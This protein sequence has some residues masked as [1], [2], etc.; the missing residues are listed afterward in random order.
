MCQGDETDVF[1]IRHHL[2]HKC[3]IATFYSCSRDLN[4]KAFEINTRRKLYLRFPKKQRLQMDLN[5]LWNYI[6]LHIQP[7]H[8]TQLHTAYLK[9]RYSTNVKS[10]LNLEKEKKKFFFYLNTSLSKKGYIF[11]KHYR[12]F[13]ND[14]K[15][16][17]SHLLLLMQS[18]TDYVSKFYFDCF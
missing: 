5:Q 12:N 4:R 17:E 6:E 13:D 11:W 16:I 3:I 14:T 8:Q 9:H 18:R 10:K 1:V 2:D 7:S 15:S